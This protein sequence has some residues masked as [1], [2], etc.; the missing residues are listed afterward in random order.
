MSIAATSRGG[1]I[2]WNGPAMRL[3]TCR[4]DRCAQVVANIRHWQTQVRRPPFRDVAYN[5]LVC[6]GCGRI[7]EG[8]GWGAR[9]AANGTNAANSEWHAWM[10][11]AGEGEEPTAGAKVA[12][13]DLAVEHRRRYGRSR[14]TTHH[15]VRGGTTACPGTSWRG[16]VAAGA[17]SP[18]PIV[19][20][21]A[22][23][24]PDID[25]EAFMATLSNREQEAAKAFFQ[26]LVNDQGFAPDDKRPA[27]VL[28]RLTELTSGDGRV[29]SVQGLVVG[30]VNAIDAVRDLG[31]DIV[32]S[33]RTGPRKR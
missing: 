15:A 26:S 5:H 13:L 24:V 4:G 18:V 19:P 7:H 20:T 30:G 6:P 2:H 12:L 16:W 22:P 14:L 27:E 29:T 21:P 11:M 33:S 1:A 17:P 32:T 23:S 3:L 8:R 9:S 10:V 28:G 31:Y 25:V